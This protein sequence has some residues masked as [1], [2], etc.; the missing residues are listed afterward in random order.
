MDSLNM[1]PTGRKLLEFGNKKHTHYKP[2]KTL[3]KKDNTLNV[4]GSSSSY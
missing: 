4:D 3:S 1:T 2:T